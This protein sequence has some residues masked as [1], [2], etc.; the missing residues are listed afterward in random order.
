MTL[1]LVCSECDLPSRNMKTCLV[2]KGGWEPCGESLLCKGNAYIMTIPEMHIFFNDP[3]K[4]FFGKSGKKADTVVVMSKH[5]SATGEPALTVH[6][7][8]NYR[9]NKFG[10]REKALVKANP[11]LMGS[12]LRLIQKYNDQPE[13]RV[14]YE[15]THHG[16]WL[17]TPT[18]YIE[19]GSDERN[20]GNTQAAETLAHVLSD[21]ETSGFKSAVGIGGG[22]YAPR[23]TE[24]ALGYKLDFGHMIPNYQLE[25][26]DDE[27]IARMIRES[28]AA[29][30]T[31]SVY[32]HKKSMKGAEAKRIA[33]ISASL[34]YEVLSSSDLEP[35]Q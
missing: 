2:G 34:G 22:H 21:M 30:F 1:L 13:F 19:I 12:A 16:P 25:G 10:G 11:F 8:G 29:S 4:A 18:F 6:P 31:D 20:W 32:I 5:S 23:F 15:V 28:C 27:D 35:I 24:V 14:C 9:D 33:D 26:A 17:E 3:D 7:I